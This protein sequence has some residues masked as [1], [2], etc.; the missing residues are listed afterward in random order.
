MRSAACEDRT[1]RMPSQPALSGDHGS[2][3]G[4]LYQSFLPVFKLMAT[5]ALQWLWS[6]TAIPL[7]LYESLARNDLIWCV[8]RQI[9]R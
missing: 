4:D 9:E 7:G 3:N 8:S 2:P 5:N 6:R 1:A